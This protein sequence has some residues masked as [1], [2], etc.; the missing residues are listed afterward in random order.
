MSPVMLLILT[1]PALILVA[2]GLLVPRSWSNTRASMMRRWITGVATAQFALASIAALVYSG[3]GLAD[4]TAPTWAIDLPLGIALY[5]DGITCLMFTMVSFVGWVICRYS[6]RYLDGDN[7]Q[8]N[9]FRS[10]ACTLGGVL[11]T[12]ASGNL[13]LFLGFW[14][15]A[16]WGLH[17]LLLHAPERSGASRG[18]WSRF[19]V[20]RIGD[21]LFALACLLLYRECGTLNLA[22]LFAYFEN[23]TSAGANI[24]VAAGLLVGSA[25][26]KSAQF[27]F[28]T[29]LPQTLET[30]TP[31]SALMHAGIVNAGGY[32]IIRTS[33][34]V[35]IAPWALTTLAIIGGVTALVA[36]MIMLT[37]TSIKR[38]LAFSTI[39]QMGFMMLQCGL[40][41][42]SAAMLHILAHSM[43][44]AY[45]FLNSG[46]ALNERAPVVIK[47]ADQKSLTQNSL[48]WPITLGTGLV[49]LAFLAAAFAVFGINPIT[50]PGGLMLGAVLCLAL[51]QWMD[52]AVKHGD[53]GLWLRCAGLAA[54][55]AFSYAAGFK[56]VDSFVVSGAPS[57]ALQ[58][59]MWAIATGFLLFSFAILFWMQRRVSIG[60]M[61]S[62]LAPWH[63]HASNG[64]YLESVFRRVFGPLASI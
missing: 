22:A 62:W 4:A 32:L 52:Q 9:Y 11:L 49:S 25:V 16:N 50:K 29:W 33:P 54:G 36:A 42:F 31:V 21:G 38:T 19:T 8:G 41:A 24:Q 56:L 14:L 63:V 45:A 48:T 12:V 18:A 34:I 26:I 3:I 7:E 40:G 5:Y 46:T 20:S 23:L 53:R 13:M 2:I 35:S 30:P 39:A 55:L 10:V 61:P 57:I 17:R 59:T 64:F 60:T 43:Y 37:Q 51:T 58:G 47:I 27:P 15:A 1:A 44:K 6:V 28:H